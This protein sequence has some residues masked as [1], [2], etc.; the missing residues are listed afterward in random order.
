M[1]FILRGIILEG[2]DSVYCP[3]DHRKKA[4]NRLIND[5]DLNKLEK[6][7]TTI[8]LNKVIENA[9]GMLSGKSH[10]R[11]IIDVNI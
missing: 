10:G 9:H 3:I 11:I 5:L 8:P 2:V 6:M 7:S 1:P 4:W